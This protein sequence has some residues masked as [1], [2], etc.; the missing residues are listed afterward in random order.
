ML[1]KWVVMNIDNATY[2]ISDDTIN[3]TLSSQQQ[4]MILNQNIEI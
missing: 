3:W 4:W 1:N 2:R